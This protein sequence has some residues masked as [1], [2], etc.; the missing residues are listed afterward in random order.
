MLRRLLPAL[1]P[2]EAASEALAATFF[3]GFEGDWLAFD[4]GRAGA[5]ETAARIVR[6]TG[7]PPDAVRSVIEEVP[8]ELS[9][10]RGTV[11]LV[12]TLQAAGVRLFF[13]SNMPAPYAA[14]LEAQHGFL[15]AFEAGLFSGRERLS[16]PDPAFFERASARFGLPPAELLFF[17]DVAANVAAARTL[18]W[19]A[20]RFTTPERCA[21]DLA[22]HG[23]PVS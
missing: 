11:A 4:Q 16:K 20:E 2:D 23:L 7:L 13:L 5:E 9:P 17:D 12:Q 3:Q 8:H 6:R 21:Q 15:S 14:H 18:G 19:H 10:I 22:A 1:A